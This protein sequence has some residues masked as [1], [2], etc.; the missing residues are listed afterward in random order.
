MRDTISRNKLR[1]FNKLRNTALS[2]AEN[3]HANDVAEIN[4][5]IAD[6]DEILSNFRVQRRLRNSLVKDKEK[7]LDKF[8]PEHLKKENFKS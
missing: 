4:Q 2:L 3:D 7:I 5:Q 1:I 6:I 8:I